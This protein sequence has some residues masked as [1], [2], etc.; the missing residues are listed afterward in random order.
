MKKI[1]LLF[2]GAL[3]L[4]LAGGLYLYNKPHRNIRKEKA[5]HWIEASKLS[6]LYQS[7]E[8]RA[9]STY[10]GKVIEVHG[11]AIY[12]KGFATTGIIILKGDGTSDVRCKL[13][14]SET[15]NAMRY[16]PGAQLTLKGVCI[17]LLL[18]VNMSECTIINQ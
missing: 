3:I 13:L 1:I 8:Q 11:E 14:E 10:L 16:Q 5:H 12:S 7:N 18:D 15:K 17:G 6:S 2:A 4:V 9:D